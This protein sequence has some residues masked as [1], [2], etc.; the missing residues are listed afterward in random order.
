MKES[1]KDY[2][3]KANIYFEIKQVIEEDEAEALSPS[4]RETVE[5]KEEPIDVEEEHSV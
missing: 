2:I 5:R 3:Q 4:K 1:N